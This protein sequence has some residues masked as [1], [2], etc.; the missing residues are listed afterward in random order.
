MENP[1]FFLLI[2]KVNSELETL[3]VLLELITNKSLSIKLVSKF[4]SLAGFWWI[5]DW[6]SGK[7]LLGWV[8]TEFKNS[9]LC[10]TIE[11]SICG[12]TF[13]WFFSQMY[14]RLQAILDVFKCII[15]ESS[16][17]KGFY[18]EYSTKEAVYSLKGEI[19]RK[20]LCTLLKLKLF[21]R[22]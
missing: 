19:S 13:R 17:Q 4:I 2:K 6:F 21:W 20:F 1:N 16:D 18:L 9:I 7:T 11:P 15:I 8:S 14:R 12:S 5:Y 3:A 22:T 10:S